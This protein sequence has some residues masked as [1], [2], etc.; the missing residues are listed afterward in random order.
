MPLK[1]SR[2]SKPSLQTQLGAGG[3]LKQYRNE[4]TDPSPES[5]ITHSTDGFTT[6]A[7]SSSSDDAFLLL[8]EVIAA[9]RD[10]IDADSK[11]FRLLGV[12]E[13]NREIEDVRER[14]TSSVYKQ[15]VSSVTNLAAWP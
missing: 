9:V 1:G 8:E 3:T 5:V 12:T 2:P 10:I 11:A 15:F 7:A 14:L 6:G 13:F 4:H